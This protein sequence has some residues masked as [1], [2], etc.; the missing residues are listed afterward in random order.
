MATGRKLQASGAKLGKFQAAGVK[1]QATS[2]KLGRQAA[3]Y[4]LP[5]P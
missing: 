2:I 3:G 4:K 5:D 1:L